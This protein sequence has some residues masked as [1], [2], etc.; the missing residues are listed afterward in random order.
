MGAATSRSL[1]NAK[2]SR[3]P[4]VQRFCTDLDFVMLSLRTI[5]EYSAT[6]RKMTHF[7]TI[8]LRVSPTEILSCN[9]YDSQLLHI[10]C[11]DFSFSHSL[12]LKVLLSIRVGAFGGN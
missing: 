5:S 7:T 1:A 8:L 10:V 4:T 3:L 12:N 9:V 11:T 2:L 6:T